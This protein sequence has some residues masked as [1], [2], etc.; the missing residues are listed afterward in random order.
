MS[1]DGSSRS[2]SISHFYNNSIRLELNFTA[3]KNNRKKTK[4][5]NIIAVNH[6]KDNFW[7]SFGG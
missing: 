1:L 3:V 6:G 2:I 5:I 7:K 4:S